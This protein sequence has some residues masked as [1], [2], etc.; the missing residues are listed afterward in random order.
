M[1]KALGLLSGGL[2]SMLAAK[3]LLEQGVNVTG[4][5]FVTPFFGSKNAEKA[6]KD[7]NM[8]LIVKNITEEHFKMLLNPKYGYGSAMN[9]CIDCH[10]LMLKIA[11]LL[12]EEKDF[13]FLFY[14]R[15]PG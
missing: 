10:A 8:P 7:L 5:S 4:I 6:A 15:S 9:P 11:G 13:D 14:R 1:T 2:D 12:M 3:V